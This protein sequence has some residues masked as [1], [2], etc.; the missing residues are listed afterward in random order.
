MLKAFSSLYYAI[1]AFLRNGEK[2]VCCFGACRLANTILPRTAAIVIIPPPYL[3][4]RS[5]TF[6]PFKHDG[7]YFVC[8]RR[9]VPIGFACLFF[10]LKLML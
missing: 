3:F 9:L 1:W 7:V 10:S 5:R 4:H 8:V 6:I 2:A